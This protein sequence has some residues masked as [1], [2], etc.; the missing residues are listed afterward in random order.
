MNAGDD[1]LTRNDV[2]AALREYS[3]AQQMVPDSATNGEMAF[4]H[5][6]TLVGIGKTEEALPLFKRAF[7]QDK[8][9][10]ELVK[11]LPKAGQLPNDSGLIRR[12]VNA[13]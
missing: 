9:W 11:R 5:A 8:N 7:A 1:A 12:I 10:I 3:T 4:W 6:V 13:K 2:A